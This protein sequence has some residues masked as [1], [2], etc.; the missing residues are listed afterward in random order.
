MGRGR[1]SAAAGACQ[2]TVRV[3]PVEATV[4]EG[5]SGTESWPFSCPSIPSAVTVTVREISSFAGTPEMEAAVS[6]LLHLYR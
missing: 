5:A 6:P 3:A 1:L 4:R 2:L